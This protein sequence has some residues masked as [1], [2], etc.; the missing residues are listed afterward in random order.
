MIANTPAHLAPLR[1]ATPPATQHS[2]AERRFM[3][4]TLQLHRF[5]SLARCRRMRGCHG[6]PQR[7]LATHGAAVPREARDLV[8]ALLVEALLVAA[9]YDDAR[10]GAGERWLKENYRREVAVFEAWIAELESRD[11]RAKQ[12]ALRAR[13]RRNRKR[14][15]NTA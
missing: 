9:R 3:C 11:A 6:E 13:L 15:L 1:T 2:L 14:A 10:A 4:G 5:C 7:C 12:Y 8:E